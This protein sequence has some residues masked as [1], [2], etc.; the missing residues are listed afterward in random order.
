M[1]FRLL[2]SRRTQGPTFSETSQRDGSPQKLLPIGHTKA[3]SQKDNGKENKSWAQSHTISLETICRRCVG[4]AHGFFSSSTPCTPHSSCRAP[5][6]SGIRPGHLTQKDL[7]RGRA[8]PLIRSETPSPIGQGSTSDFLG[9][10]DD[11]RVTN[12]TSLNLVFQ[13]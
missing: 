5:Q 4:S 10:K 9:K 12:L 6:R 13:R 8:I 11:W 3:T 7:P 2:V 1:N